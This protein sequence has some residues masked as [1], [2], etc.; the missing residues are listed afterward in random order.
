[1]AR[2]GEML[3]RRSGEE[4]DQGRAREPLGMVGR[5]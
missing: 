1:M 3:E 2:E 5:A 4:E